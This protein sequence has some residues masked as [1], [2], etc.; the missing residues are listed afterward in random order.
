MHHA[1]K[2]ILLVRKSAQKMQR[3]RAIRVSRGIEEM[4][5]F[6]LFIVLFCTSLNAYLSGTLFEAVVHP[7]YQ[8][9]GYWP[10]LPIKIKLASGICGVAICALFAIGLLSGLMAKA[11]SDEFIRR[12]KAKPTP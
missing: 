12:S 10:V 8:L 4:P 5:D 6:P 1:R 2:L 9:L 7:Y 3:R 11:F